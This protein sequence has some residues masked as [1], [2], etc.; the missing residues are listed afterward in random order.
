M[1]NSYVLWSFD[2]YME[3]YFYYIFQLVLSL[4]RYGKISQ[5]LLKFFLLFVLFLAALGLLAARR[6]SAAVACGCLTA[7]ASFAVAHRLERGL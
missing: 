1:I 7:V 2:C 5:V 4:Q 6:L 3:K